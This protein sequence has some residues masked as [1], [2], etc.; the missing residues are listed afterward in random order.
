M[1]ESYF[2]KEQ[3]DHMRYL[4]SIPREQRCASGWHLIGECGEQP[5]RSHGLC[6]TC[7]SGSRWCTCQ[8]AD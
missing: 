4:D 2:N 6:P 8:P 5:C 3:Q 1:A 7:G